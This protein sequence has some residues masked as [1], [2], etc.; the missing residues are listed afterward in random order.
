[1]ILGCGGDS[2]DDATADVAGEVDSAAEEG[3]VEVAQ[4]VESDPSP[5][6]DAGA[7]EATDAPDD[8]EGD[9]GDEGPGSITSVC[10][11]GEDEAVYTTNVACEASGGTEVSLG[12]CPELCCHHPDNSYSWI[13]PGECQGS[14]I[15]SHPGHCE[16]VCCELPGES[17]ATLLQGNCEVQGGAELDEAACNPSDEPICCRYLDGTFGS[18]TPADC[19]AGPGQ[20]TLAE[21]CVEVCCQLGDDSLEL[22]LT[23]NCLMQN[24]AA[25]D[26]T[27]CEVSEEEVCCAEGDEGYVLVSAGAC[28]PEDVV[29]AEMCAAGETKVCC[30]GD[31]GVFQMVPSEACD[32]ANVVADTMCSEAPPQ[33]CCKSEEGIVW[34]PE[35][36]CPD[37][38][39]L[40][41][42][43]CALEFCCK[44]MEGEGVG[45]AVMASAPECMEL[46]GAV[47]YE[48]YCEQILCCETDE[49]P[50]L[51][52]FMECTF[53]ALQETEACTPMQE[54]A[55]CKVM[56][57]PDAGNALMALPSDCAELGGAFVPEDYCTQ[58]ICCQGEDGPALMPYAACTFLELT[59]TSACDPPSEVACCKDM[60]NPGLGDAYLAT[61]EDCL[62]QKGAPVFEEYCTQEVCCDMGEGPQTMPYSEC[63]F[64]DMVATYTGVEG[65]PCSPPEEEA[66]CK[67]SFGVNTGNVVMATPTECAE[68]GGIVTLQAYCEQSVCCET[69][70]GLAF[71]PF[72]ECPFLS[73]NADNACTPPEE[74]GCCQIVLGPETGN[75]LLLTPTECA[76]V[77][78]VPQSEDYCTQELCCQTDD[79]P[80]TLP[81]LECPF[82]NVIE[83][84][85]CVVEEEGC[86]KISAGPDTGNVVM[87]TPSACEA[88]SGVLTEQSYCDQLMCCNT[89]D[90]PQELPFLECPFSDVSFEEGACDVCCQSSSWPQFTPASECEPELTLDDAACEVEVCCATGEGDPAEGALNLCLAEGGEVVEESLCNPPAELLCC[91][92]G[93]GTAFILDLECELQGGTT[94]AP[95]ECVVCCEYPGGGIG[96]DPAAMCVAGLGTIVA[97]ELCEPEADICCQVGEDASL[98]SPSACEAQEGVEVEESA[99]HVCCKDPLGNGPEYVLESECPGVEPE[100][101]CEAMLC[102][103]LG[104]TTSYI[105]TAECN[106]QGG[107][108]AGP[109]ECQVCCEFSG[110][111]I[112]EVPA[113]FC[114]AGMGTFVDD[115]LCA[116]E[117]EAICCQVD[118]DAS[119][120]TPSSCSE[121]GGA[122]TEIE[123][124]QVCCKNPN[125]LGPEYVFEEACEPTAIQPE[126][127]CAM[128]ACDAEPC[129]NGG[130][131]SDGGDAETYTCECEG[132]GF[133]GENCEIAEAAASCDASS[134]P[135]TRRTSVTAV[136]RSRAALSAHRHAM[137][138]TR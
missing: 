26:D 4:D 23:G 93:E 25:V 120:L 84:D 66:C 124:C 129:Q 99:C 47:V 56:S 15:P 101:S 113:E 64:L 8:P 34:V 83:S 51:V 10:C 54:E 59:E 115:A 82:A 75:V 33:Q 50:A 49:G 60:E 17:P 109:T 117:E 5:E 30:E 130:V 138:A 98:T 37:D 90:G 112:E 122:E 69:A 74:E 79:G 119:L 11:Q 57:G 6:S 116:P 18:A 126:S 52:P 77:Y 111:G 136:T 22:L 121:S 13:P 127:V 31:D 95:S 106:S 43:M 114:V 131:C 80:Q 105:S 81:L 2:N 63:T 67:I 21:S 46:G 35:G 32:E 45:N 107:S 28:D 103:A 20:E 27:L 71:V 29:D 7:D 134:L 65:D 88:I 89:E 53:L 137:R 70:E 62:A 42:E 1:M 39:V 73:V 108:T 58:E 38:N 123:A 61:P 133:T 87:A 132:T 12:L 36:E 48:G 44:I 72:L 16:E 41:D 96:Q 118:E 14:G 135:Q 104:E 128:T 68:Q 24:G 3:D 55:C 102:C 125:G 91:D 78:G 110:G 86:C 9:A 100:S 92:L 76:V 97:D 40:A 19:A 85:Q 94:A